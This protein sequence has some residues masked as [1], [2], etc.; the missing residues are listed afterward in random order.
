MPK[1]DLKFQYDNLCKNVYDVSLEDKTSVEQDEII[2]LF[3]IFKE[4]VQSIL[5]LHIDPN[6][7]IEF[8]QQN[9]AEEI[10]Q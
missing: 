8:I 5:D 10:Q 4:E 3:K 9:Q 2:I 1:D 7:M 6:N